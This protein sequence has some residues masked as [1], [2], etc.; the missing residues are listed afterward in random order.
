[1]DIF[2]KHYVCEMNFFFS[3]D[4]SMDFLGSEE[5]IFNPWIAS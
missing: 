4:F 5:I 3:V 2:H 1:M